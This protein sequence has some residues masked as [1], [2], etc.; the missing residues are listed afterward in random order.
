MKN[1]PK[2]SLDREDFGFGLPLARGGISSRGSMIVPVILLLA[3]AA[4][5]G[6]GFDL[7][8]ILPEPRWAALRRVVLGLG[9]SLQWLVLFGAGFYLALTSGML[10]E[11]R[12]IHKRSSY[13]VRKVMLF[14][15]LRSHPGPIVVTAWKRNL[16]VGAAAILASW[17]FASARPLAVVAMVVSFLIYSIIRITTPPAVVFLGTSDVADLKWHW[18]LLFLARP[19]R[20]VSCLELTN[21]QAPV[22][23]W[24]LTF[25]CFRSSNEGWWET[26]QAL[27]QLTPLV[28]I[29]GTVDTPALER[30]VRSLLVSRQAWKCIVLHG[31]NGE[32]ELLD[33]VGA[34]KGS[35]C[36]LSTDA[37]VPVVTQ[38]LARGELP[39]P[40]LPVSLVVREMDLGS[41][42]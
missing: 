10:Y 22:G 15:T 20:V 1:R 8:R 17:W 36:T 40:G 33:A 24:N 25:D 35:F 28:L 34:P 21:A 4:L 38:I 27:L 16:Y 2:P 14:L 12:R 26:V 37:V 32:C 42:P 9:L 18:T 41:Q 23:S 3:L 6:F 31:L 30:E 7:W 29:D 19:L 11:T 13:A 5:T 39:S